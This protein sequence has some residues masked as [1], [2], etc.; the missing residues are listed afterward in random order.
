MLNKY[1]TLPEHNIY[2][3]GNE[4]ITRIF[5]NTFEFNSTVEDTIA[6][7]EEVKVIDNDDNLLAVGFYFI[8]HIWSNS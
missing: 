2:L 6:N 8:T 5:R 3:N 4:K 7:F 1:F